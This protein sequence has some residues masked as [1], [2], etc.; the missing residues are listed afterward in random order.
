MDTITRRSD[1]IVLAA[2]RSKKTKTKKK[3]KAQYEHTVGERLGT[4][5]MYGTAETAPLKQTAGK[6][7]EAAESPAT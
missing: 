7:T 5:V 3:K 1:T 4:N 6:R 2:A